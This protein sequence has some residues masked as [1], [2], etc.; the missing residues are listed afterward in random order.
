MVSGWGLKEFEVLISVA[1]SA[2]HTYVQLVMVGSWS[3]D[4]SLLEC[5]VRKH[6]KVGDVELRYAIWMA[7]YNL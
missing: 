5:I 3:P 1:G 6:S 7:L 4:T 2:N